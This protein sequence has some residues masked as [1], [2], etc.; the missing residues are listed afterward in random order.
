MIYTNSPKTSKT[1]EIH[2]LR[3][4]R[5]VQPYPVDQTFSK[6]H[7]VNSCFTHV[8]ATLEPD[9]LAIA[10][11]ECKEGTRSSEVDIPSRARIQG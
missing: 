7:N 5:K 2:A 8:I 11:K 9:A 4:V 10:R 3:Y 1:S 6:E